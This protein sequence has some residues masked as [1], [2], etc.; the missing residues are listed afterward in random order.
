MNTALV[1]VKE[2]PVSAENIARVVSP[3]SAIASRLRVRTLL[4]VPVATVVALAVHLFVSKSEPV[5]D[6]RSYTVFLGILLAASL[7]A[8]F[9]FTLSDIAHNTRK[10]LR[11]LKIRTELETGAV[12]M[13][14]TGRAEPRF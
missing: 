3:S 11:L 8:A 6:T 9:L 14:S 5:A 13:T 2:L 7:A 1:Q 10:T 12:R 4:A